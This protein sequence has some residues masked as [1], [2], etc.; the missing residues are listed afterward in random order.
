MRSPTE[1]LVALLLSTTLS[2][3]GGTSTAPCPPSAPNPPNAKNFVARAP[4]T[5]DA[6]L[7]A[8]ALPRIALFGPFVAKADEPPFD[9][10][11]VERTK[12]SDEIQHLVDDDQALRMKAP[13]ADAGLPMDAIRAW[14]AADLRRR[15]RV[16]ELYAAGCLSTAK[17]FASAAL[18][19]QHGTVPEHYLQAYLFASRAV[20]LGDV[21][22]TSMMALAIDRYLVS[23]GHK[24]L[25]G[26]QAFSVGNL[27]NATGPEPCTCMSQVEHSFPDVERRAYIKMGLE[28][29]VEWVHSLNHGRT[30]CPADV[31]C[32]EP[33]LPTPR[34]TVPG[35]W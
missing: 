5:V 29:K 32:T 7:D 28:D 30:D 34:G 9:C 8:G 2:A 10:A 19:F 35:M 4:P 14:M 25:F 16:A 1:L 13:D 15:T 22:E 31:E 12:A 21:R 11:P 18:I 3:C 6:P 20:A 26:S 17:D 24:Q 27:P 33:L 23:T